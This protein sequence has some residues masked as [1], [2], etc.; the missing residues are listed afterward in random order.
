M[1]ESFPTDILP[2][3]CGLMIADSYG[4]AIRREAPEHRISTIRRR[5]QLLRFALTASERLHRLSD[6]RL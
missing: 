6:P 4:A 5:R 2:G 1:P 3:D